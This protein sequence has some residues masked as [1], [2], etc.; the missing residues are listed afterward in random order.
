MSVFLNNEMQAVY[1]FSLGEK[2]LDSLLPWLLNI[3][4]RAP[5]SSVIIVGTHV[6][7]VRPGEEERER[8]EVACELK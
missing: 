2:E 3:Q 8:E 6:D 1:N 7:K 4:A 5:Q